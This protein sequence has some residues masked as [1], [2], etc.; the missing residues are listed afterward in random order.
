MASMAGKADVNVTLGDMWVKSNLSSFKA[1][2]V[3]FAVTN[4]GNTGHGFAITTADP[5]IAVG[6][7]E[8]SSMLAMGKVLSNGQSETISATLKPG[9]YEL[10]C[11]VPGHYMAGQHIPFKVTS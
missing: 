10:I 6:S 9:S 11:H 4:T 3:S 1:G 7:V 2:K 5:K 8:H